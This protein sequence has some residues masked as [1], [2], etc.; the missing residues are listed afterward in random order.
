M[1]RP[2]P[3]YPDQRTSSDR[4]GTSGW[5]QNL[6]SAIQGQETTAAQQLPYS[7]DARWRL[8]PVRS[9]RFLRQESLQ[10]SDQS[11][12]RRRRGL[13]PYRPCALTP[14]PAPVAPSRHVRQNSEVVASITSFSAAG[15]CARAAKRTTGPVSFKTPRDSERPSPWPDRRR[16]AS[17]RPCGGV[18]DNRGNIRDRRVST[19]L[20]LQ[21]AC[22]R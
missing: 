20:E 3:V 21:P 1:V 22:L 12:E 10:T 18:L 5:C 9:I 4:P 16:R 19:R 15:C 17:S 14:D 2:L 8:G 13:R 6:P 11:A 7:P